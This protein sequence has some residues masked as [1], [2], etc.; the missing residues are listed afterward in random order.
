MGHVAAECPDRQPGDKLARREPGKPWCEHH[1]V[2]SHSTAKCRA[3]NN[4]K[5]KAEARATH[6]VDEE[7]A[8]S[9]DAPD[10][11]TYNE[12]LE[13]WESQQ[14]MMAQDYS[15]TLVARS[16]ANASRCSMARPSARAAST[17]HPGLT[18]RG[19]ETQRIKGRLSNMPMGSCPVTL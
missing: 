3:L 2:N 4:D 1:R 12:L 7:P 13:F 14:T 19:P 15:G 16:M 6:A 8:S 17:F 18:K 10:R 9:H 5:P 11:P